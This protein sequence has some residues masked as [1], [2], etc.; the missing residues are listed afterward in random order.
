MDE[1]QRQT[2]DLYNFVQDFQKPIEENKNNTIR[3]S[4]KTK[5]GQQFQV[6]GL[7]QQ[8]ELFVKDNNK[9]NSFPIRLSVEQKHALIAGLAFKDENICDFDEIDEDDSG[10][11]TSGRRI[12]KNSRKAS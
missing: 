1:E 12:Q 4:F 2:R 10:K 8:Q 3:A 7:P 9:K 5:D 11:K 6:F